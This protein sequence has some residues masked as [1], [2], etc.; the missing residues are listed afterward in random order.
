MKK[1]NV[2][3]KK[4]EELYNKI[5]DE[6]NATDYVFLTKEQYDEGDEDV[7]DAPYTFTVDRWG[8]YIQYAIISIR[9]GGYILCGGTGEDHGELIEF[10]IDIMSMDQV[11]YMMKDIVLINKEI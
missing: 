2:R 7:L 3:I 10:M 1:T 8:H 6:A 4:I 11:I 9:D 5:Y